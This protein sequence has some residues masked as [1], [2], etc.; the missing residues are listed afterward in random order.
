MRANVAGLCLSLVFGAA[1]CMGQEAPISSTQ[2]VPPPTHPWRDAV[3]C[4]GFYT[5]EKVSDELRLVS[6][7][8]SE[9]KITFATGDIVYLSRGSNQ[10]VK[11]GDRFSVVRPDRDALRVQWFKWQDKLRNA[12]GTYYLDLGELEVIKAQPNVAIAKVSGS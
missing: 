5:N 1:A 8:Q 9:Y 3:Y 4:A 12:M 11:E 6:G 10:G 7:E 2:A